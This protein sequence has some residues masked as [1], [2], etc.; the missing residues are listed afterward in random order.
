MDVGTGKTRLREAIAER[1][2][3]LT[4]VA[5][6]CGVSRPA[7]AQWFTDKPSWRPIPER[8]MAT[9]RELLAASPGV[10]ASPAKAGRPR[11]EPQL[12]MGASAALQPPALP[13]RR[14]RR[15]PPP[16]PAPQ[17]MYRGAPPFLGQEPPPRSP[18]H[19]PE[20]W[21]SPPVMPPPGPAYV[22]P[23]GPRHSDIVAA[24]NRASQQSERRDVRSP[25]RGVEFPLG[26]F[27]GLTGPIRRED[28]EAFEAQLTLSA[29]EH[30]FAGE[31][32]LQQVIE[33]LRTAVRRHNSSFQI[34]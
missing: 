34:V 7:V 6:A 1:G 21:A 13:A 3:T 23:V 19:Y 4:D 25:E 11:S 15:A 10:L 12:A 26:Q 2:L 16:A 33:A 31:P 24:H 9:I 22:S 5:Y 29:A 14:R 17:P 18:M 27:F 30:G 20:H 8:H 32:E 28:L